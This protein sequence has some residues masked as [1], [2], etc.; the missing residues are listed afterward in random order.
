MNI[1]CCTYIDNL[2][3][4][5]SIDLIINTFFVDFNGGDDSQESYPQLTYTQLY[6]KCL[7]KLHIHL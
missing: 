2:S 7:I 4:K 1:K 5:K 6:N 3:N